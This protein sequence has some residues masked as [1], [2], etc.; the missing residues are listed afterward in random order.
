MKYL[1]IDSAE[2]VVELLEKKPEYIPGYGARCPLCGSWG[3]YNNN[4]KKMK[5]NKRR[6]YYICSMCGYRFAAIEK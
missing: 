5:N 2:K 4:T 1:S 3:N 6:R